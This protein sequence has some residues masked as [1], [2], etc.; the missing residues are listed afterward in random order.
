MR[1]LSAEIRRERKNFNVV[2]RSP[3]DGK[4]SEQRGI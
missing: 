2:K 3:R 1:T 4:V